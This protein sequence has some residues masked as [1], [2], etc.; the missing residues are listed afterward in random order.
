MTLKEFLEEIDVL[1]HNNQGDHAA[2]DFIDA[3]NK[4]IEIINKY[5]SEAQA[6]IDAENADNVWTYE[7]FVNSGKEA[8]QIG[9]LL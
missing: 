2:E 1:A 4:A 7:D 6:R 8:L 3:A 9:G 5:K